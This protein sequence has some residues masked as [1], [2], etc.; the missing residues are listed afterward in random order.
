[1]PGQRK[2]FDA[3]NGLPSLVPELIA[4]VDSLQVVVSNRHVKLTAGRQEKASLQ[5]TVVRSN[6][7]CNVNSNVNRSVGSSMVTENEWD[8]FPVGIL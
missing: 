1:M 5:P 3:L 7:G 6:D 4:E 8:R 2:V